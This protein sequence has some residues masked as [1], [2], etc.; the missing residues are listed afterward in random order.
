MS[1]KVFHSYQVVERSDR[2]R[3]SE[4][5][6]EVADGKIFGGESEKAVGKLLAKQDYVWPDHATA[7]CLVAPKL[8]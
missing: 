1:S 6:Q 7:V 3:C 5:Q 2:Q 4:H 8:E